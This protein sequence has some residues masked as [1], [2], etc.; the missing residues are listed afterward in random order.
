[1]SF[2]ANG[3]SDGRAALTAVATL[4]TGGFAGGVIGAA[5]LSEP[6]HAA[7]VQVKTVA[8]TKRVIKRSI[9]QTEKVELKRPPTPSD[10]SPPDWAAVELDFTRFNRH[11]L[12]AKWKRRKSNE[13]SQ[14][15]NRIQG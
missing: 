7:K 1:M 14:V 12:G 13:E 10:S 5:G 11:L 6:E 2:K 9:E 8:N 4:V 15:S 3:I